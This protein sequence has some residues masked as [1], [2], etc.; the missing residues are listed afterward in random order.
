MFSSTSGPITVDDISGK[1]CWIC[2]ESEDDDD[3]QNGSSKFVHPCGCS[4]VAHATCLFSWIDAQQK[5]SP[6]GL[7]FSGAGAGGRAGGQDPH[8][9]AS[10]RC[11]QC[12][13]PYR[14]T[15][16]AS[17]PERWLRSLL[18]RSAHTLS[19][20][21][22]TALLAALGAGAYVICNSYGRLA[23]RL[24]VGRKLANR[25]FGRT[26][27][28]HVR[29]CFLFVGTWRGVLTSYGHRSCMSTSR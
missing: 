2:A 11:P 1:S 14:I 3:A 27:S 22:G 7:N 18:S 6:R 16:A 21:T 13:Q 23:T 8:S 20:H 4:L 12:Q 5:S 29:K 17:R 26:W 9:M 28:W 19:N 10:A 25:V 15:D 24:L